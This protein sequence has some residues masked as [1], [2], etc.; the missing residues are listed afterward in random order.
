MDRLIGRKVDNFRRVIVI[1]P[2]PPRFKL[3]NP[4]T[5]YTKTFL[6]LLGCVYTKMHVSISIP[7]PP[8]KV[9]LTSNLTLPKGLFITKAFA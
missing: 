2:P 1:H 3:N 5:L 4:Q 7:P 9:V 6:K 8:K